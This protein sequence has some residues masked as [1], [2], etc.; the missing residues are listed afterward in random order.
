[1]SQMRVQKYHKIITIQPTEFVAYCKNDKLKINEV[2]RVGTM[3]EKLDTVLVVDD[4]ESI[5]ALLRDFL[6]NASFYV[7]TAFNT[8]E[9]LAVFHQSVVDCMILDIMMPGQSGFDLCRE[10]REQ[11]N[12]PILFLSARSDD[13]DK[14]RGL[15]LGGG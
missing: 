8:D 13:V 3:M 11:S 6:E 1:M 14:I 12:I 7:K 5:V 2:E 9:A 10:I 4:D 15:A